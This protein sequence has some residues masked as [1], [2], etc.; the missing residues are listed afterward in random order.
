MTRKSQQPLYTEEQR[1][2]LWDV[3][4][5]L[6]KALGVTDPE[7]GTVMYEPHNLRVSMR[8]EAAEAIVRQRALDEALLARALDVI[9]GQVV[10][11][12]ESCRAADALRTRLKATS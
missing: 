7:D 8:L 10:M 6:D 4:E 3:V 9:E 11:D 2:R 1:I 5:A 12:R